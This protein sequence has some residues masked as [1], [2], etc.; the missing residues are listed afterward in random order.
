MTAAVQ[1][2]TVNTTLN[3]FREVADGGL[4]EIRH[5]TV[6]ST[7]MKYNTQPVVVNDIR[8]NEGDFTLDKQGF[9]LVTSATKVKAFDEKTVKEQYYQELIDLIKET[10]DPL[11]GTPLQKNMC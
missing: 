7:R 6:G 1:S 10:Y 5:G 8:S 3:Y 9:Q 11:S 4:S 2:P